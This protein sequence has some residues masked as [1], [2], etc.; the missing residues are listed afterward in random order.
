MEEGKSTCEP[1]ANAIHGDADLCT[2]GIPDEQKWS[3]EEQVSHEEKLGEF[4]CCGA[5]D[6]CALLRREPDAAPLLTP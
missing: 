5:V 6:R 2:Q 3:E 1:I 4:G